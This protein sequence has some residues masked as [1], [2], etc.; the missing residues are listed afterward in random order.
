MWA[1]HVVVVIILVKVVVGQQ[2]RNVNTL[3]ML[4]ESVERQGGAAKQFV[5]KILESEKD[6]MEHNRD[7]ENHAG[8]LI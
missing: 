3:Q 7:R 4:M 5:Y 2:G 1:R 6:A 8:K